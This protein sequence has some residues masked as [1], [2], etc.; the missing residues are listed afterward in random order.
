MPSPRIAVYG[1][2]NV[3]LHDD[4]F[5][6]QVIRYLLNNWEFPEAVFIEDLGTP[7]LELSTHL[8]GYDLVVLIDAV[9]LHAAAGTFVSMSSEEIVTHPGGI[10]L[11]PHDP[12]LAETLVTMQLIDD[13]PRDVMLVGAVPHDVT[14]GVGMADCVRDRIGDVARFVVQLLER[15]GVT[16][17]SREPEAPS[18]AWWESPCD[19]PAYLVASGRRGL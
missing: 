7:G 10:R 19:E 12:S 2:G 15:N 6:P 3:L 18:V 4:A 13:G 11:G 14:P 9:K 17:T 8:A 16:A 1:L 5:G